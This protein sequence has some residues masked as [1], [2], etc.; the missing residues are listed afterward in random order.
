MR[1]IFVRH[2][3]PDYVHDSLTEKG[4]KEAEILAERTKKWKVDEIYCS[5]LGRAQATMKPSLENWPDKTPVTYD[6]LQ[7]FP[8]RI[9]DPVTG[10]KRICWDLMPS[11]FCDKEDLFDKDKWYTADCMKAGDVEEKFNI[12]KE[13][14]DKLLVEHGYNNQGNGLFRVEKH[15]DDTLVFFCHFA[16]TAV[17]VGHLTGIAPFLLWQG[18]IMS[19]TSVTVLNSEEREVGN[20]YF[21]VQYW[22]DARHLV[23]AGEPI[24]QSGY[25][26]DIFQD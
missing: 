14:I 8:A 23:E 19:P 24:S 9:P 21:R 15:S 20:G 3:E 11:Y 13:G 25:F 16:I 5:P 22:G 7:E 6:W 26:A 17:I 12:T 4:F 10:E 18:F 2:A 1:L